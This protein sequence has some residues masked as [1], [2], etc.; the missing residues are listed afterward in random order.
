[1]PTIYILDSIKIL[2]FFD[3]HNPPHF[4]AIYNEHEE[5]IIIPTL[6][7]LRGGLPKNQSRKLEDW[8]EGHLEFII[9]KW[10]EFNPDNK[11]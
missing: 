3:D 4:H 1:M 6:E 8:A 11:L 9:N 10:N 2:I 7:S 5:L